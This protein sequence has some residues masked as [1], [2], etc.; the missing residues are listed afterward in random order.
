MSQPISQQPGSSL[1]AMTDGTKAD[2]NLL[3]AVEL[4]SLIRQGRVLA[5]EA[6]EGAIS[7]YERFNSAVNAVILT[8]I[9]EARQRATEVDAALAAGERWG[10]LAGV[11]VTIKEA[12]DWKDTPST[13]GNPA[14]VNNMAD[15]DA[16][17]V[18][19][20]RDAG[21]VIWGK[22]NVPLML[23]DWQS[24]N[25]IYGC[26]NNPWDLTRVPGG[27]S[28]GSAASLATGMASLE[29]GSDIGASIRNPAHYCGVFGHKPTFGL[30]PDT[31]HAVP[32]TSAGSD[33]GVCG[34]L[35]RSAADLDLALDV[36]A[37]PDGFNAAGYSVALRPE[38]RDTLG[39]FR[40]G[41]MLDTPVVRN[42]SA[43]IDTLQR[44]ID[45]LAA[46]GADLSEAAPDIDQHEFHENYLMLLRA[47]TGAMADDTTWTQ[48]QS[49]AYRYQSG[50]ADYQSL[51]D[52]AMTMSHRE[53]YAHHHKREGYRQAWARFFDDYDLLL[54][55]IAAGAA[56]V[57]D[58]TGTRTT[59]TI[60]IDGYQEL[61]V[62]QL[63]WAGWSCSV[64][65][66]GTV[67]PVGLTADGL[68][69]PVGIQIV[70]PHL[71]DRRSIRYASLIERTLGGF[72]SPPGYE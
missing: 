55:P 1:G 69:L 71:G 50:A 10:P 52:H 27:S 29:L 9:D 64:Y 22:T 13:W 24:F 45:A 20:Y 63:F 15:T 60:D 65:L 16:V 67:A 70:A 42:S 18:A 40:V 5:V 68:N 53:W 32:G 19:R 11:P 56:F 58:H 62:D 46:A 28:G 49:R 23:G 34:P 4:A 35:A 3:P 12:F 8:R 6:L 72:V 7:R 54:C 44:A 33:I 43:M 66:P 37:G 51:V 41:V 30:V 38:H 31:G 57:H 61:G 36:L 47:A 2:L 39:A 17:T 14:W 48:A 26:T 21:A 59:R 25:D